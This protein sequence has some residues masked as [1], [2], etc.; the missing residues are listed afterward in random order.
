MGIV[1][2]TNIND[3]EAICM[4][5][6]QL[7]LEGLDYRSLDAYD[8]DPEPYCS[9]CD[10]SN[11]YFPK[12][13]TTDDEIDKLAKTLARTL[14]EVGS[15]P[16]RGEGGR[17]HRIEFKGGRYADQEIALGGYCESALAGHFART[18]RRNL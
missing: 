13:K 7:F 6:G 3:V 4:T 15:D 14:F 9:Q 12:R 8:N 5:C 18:L 2:P 1:L 11:L 16:H 10:D 17:V